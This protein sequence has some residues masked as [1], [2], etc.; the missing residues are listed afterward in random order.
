MPL[1]IVEIQ[2]EQDPLNDERKEHK[3]LVLKELMKDPNAFAS[4][5]RLPLASS[6]EGA[7]VRVKLPLKKEYRFAYG[8]PLTD[9]SG[10]GPGSSSMEQE[11]DDQI[12]E[13]QEG[14][15]QGES[16]EG[17]EEQQ[18]GSGTSGDGEEQDE[19]PSGQQGSEAGDDKQG[20][21]QRGSGQKPKDK[22]QSEDEQGSTD[23]SGEEEGKGEEEEDEK[24]RRGQEVGRL[25][26][27]QPGNQRFPGLSDLG[28]PAE[29]EADSDKGDRQEGGDKAGNEAGENTFDT[30][31]SIDDIYGR[32]QEEF[33][34]PDLDEKQLSTL[35]TVRVSFPAGFRRTGPMTNLSGRRTSE[36]RLKRLRGQ[37]KEGEID[38]EVLDEEPWYPEDFRFRRREEDEDY[39][40]NAVVYFVHD[41]SASIGEQKLRIIRALSSHFVRAIRRV[42]KE[43]KVV[44][45]TFDTI[46][47]ERTEEEFFYKASSGGTEI[48]RGSQKILDISRERYPAD[49]W[50]SF[51]LFFTDGENEQR[52]MPNMRRTFE[53][54]LNAQ[55]LV[56]YFEVMP[57][58][59]GRY[60]DG[61]GG[62]YTYNALTEALRKDLEEEYDNFVSYLIM[63][64]EE[65]AKAFDRLLETAKKIERKKGHA[66]P[67][68][69]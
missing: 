39:I 11:R 14:E 28:D 36:E 30:D 32:V 69:V 13:Q 44:F 9:Q 51:T 64:E 31:I 65:V 21:G 3:R 66:R 46:A 42:H 53:E 54:L 68:A 67:A 25:P 58:H 37:G 4:Q 60:Y 15:G 26:E 61:D 10:E 47:H 48:S 22:Q 2:N 29:G 41:S 24:L 34:L 43:V 17:D 18:E 7:R 27:D 6:A 57:L 33:N 38:E 16:G 56:G 49:E 5:H 12:G 23:G 20:G 45:I 59:S 8:D 40:T 1:R 35:R 55:K 52:D 62:E 19:D 50:N 63:S